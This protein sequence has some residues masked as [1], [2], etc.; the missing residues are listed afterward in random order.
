MAV[1]L[2]KRFKMGRNVQKIGIAIILACALFSCAGSPR[3]VE[4]SAQEV[5]I[6]MEGR[7]FSSAPEVAM[8]GRGFAEGANAN[9]NRMIAYSVSMEL[10]VKDPD[11]T[12]RLIIEQVNHHNGF[13]VRETDN[14]IATRIPAENMDNF[15]ENMRTL[16]RVES[17]N[18]TG[19]DITDQYRDNILRLESL[20]TVRDRY[21][22]L[23]ARADTV[24][25][26]LSIERELERVNLEIERLEGR[27]QRA[28]QSVS[29]SL[30]TVRFGERA[31]PGPLG[32]IFYGLYRGLKWLFIWN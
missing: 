5:A 19:T 32:W 3:A 1:Q 18:K 31:K 16:G 8:A 26:I 24:S 4:R 21:L 12:R 23:L 7:G 14:S 17:E 15:L 30:I 25:D 20:R 27:I 6:A 28:E 9:D 10:S 29:Y 13:I 11:E 22:A 2:T